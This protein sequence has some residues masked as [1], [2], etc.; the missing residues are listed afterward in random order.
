MPADPRAQPTRIAEISC[1]D[2]DVAVLCNSN[3]IDSVDEV[4]DPIGTDRHPANVAEMPT[5]YCDRAA[6]R[7]SLPNLVFLAHRE[8]AV[9]GRVADEAV[10]IEAEVRRDDVDDAVV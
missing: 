3:E 1:E 10:I 6:I 5:R 9:A 2:R 7:R 8:V 4:D